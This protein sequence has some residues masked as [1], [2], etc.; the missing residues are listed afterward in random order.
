MCKENLLKPFIDLEHPIIIHSA[1][2]LGKLIQDY[3]DEHLDRKFITFS[4]NWIND[5][6][7]VLCKE[8]KSYDVNI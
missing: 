7:E 8:I 1:L 3:M 6:W 2:E 4:E 5:N